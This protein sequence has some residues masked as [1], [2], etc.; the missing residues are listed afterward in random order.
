[1]AR[2]NKALIDMEEVESLLIAK[3]LTKLGRD[4][5]ISCTVKVFAK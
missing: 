5:K 2:Q 3:L 4:P 1:M